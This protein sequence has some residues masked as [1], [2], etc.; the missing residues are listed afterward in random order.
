MD[1]EDFLHQLVPCHI[2]SC[3]RLSFSFYF[4]TFFPFLFTWGNPVFFKPHSEI[5]SPTK[6]FSDTS[7][8]IQS[9]HG[10]T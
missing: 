9:T 6:A 4:H 3:M 5:T 10:I 7:S 8:A 1:Y 2:S